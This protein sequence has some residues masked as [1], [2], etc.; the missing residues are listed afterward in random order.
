VEGYDT[1]QTTAIGAKGRHPFHLIQVPAAAGV[2]VKVI[3]FVV[4][5][6]IH[7]L[8]I[9]DILLNSNILIH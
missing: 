9:P 4:D 2:Q 5:P 1:V 3:T 8:S 6:L 7:A